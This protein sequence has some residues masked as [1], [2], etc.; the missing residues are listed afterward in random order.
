VHSAQSPNFA[1]SA[2]VESTGIK[3]SSFSAAL[4]F[5]SALLPRERKTYT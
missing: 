1:P 2:N 3:M 4:G 5:L